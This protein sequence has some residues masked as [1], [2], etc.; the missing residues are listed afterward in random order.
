MLLGSTRWCC[1]SPWVFS[2]VTLEKR[3]TWA[4]ATKGKPKTCRNT[5]M[6]NSVSCH[7]KPPTESAMEE[8]TPK[9][10]ISMTHPYSTES[11]LC[12]CLC[13][14]KYE[15]VEYVEGYIDNSVMLS[16]LVG[17][18]GRWGTRHQRCYRWSNR[19]PGP[20]AQQHADSASAQ[21]G[22][23]QS[24][25]RRRDSTSRCS[26]APHS[27]STSESMESPWSEEGMVDMV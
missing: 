9:Q 17:W 3:E 5:P 13:V 26:P 21:T 24:P 15:G 27:Q 25:P 18:P 23:Q 6:M 10:L 2:A 19:W 7:G 11:F 12:L 1:F 14:P 16:D 4:T 8:K 22:S 20:P